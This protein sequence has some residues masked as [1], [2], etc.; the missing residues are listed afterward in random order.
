[1]GLTVF[2]QIRIIPLHRLFGP[3]KAGGKRQSSVRSLE[4]KGNLTQAAA[5]LSLMGGSAYKGS[6]RYKWTLGLHTPNPA[7]EWQARCLGWRS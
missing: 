6:E 4:L 1:M 7:L 5:I 2:R 3:L